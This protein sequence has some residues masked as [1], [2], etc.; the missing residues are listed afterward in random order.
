[1]ISMI[2]DNLY[3][4]DEIRTANVSVSILIN[5]L[6]LEIDDEINNIQKKKNIFHPDFEPEKI[7][8]LFS[9]VSKKETRFCT[10]D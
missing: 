7:T 5:I 4:L 1:M 2:V 8:K 6:K 9:S 10:T 3:S